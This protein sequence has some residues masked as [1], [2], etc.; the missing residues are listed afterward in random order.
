MSYGRIT[1]GLRSVEMTKQLVSTPKMVPVVEALTIPFVA[2]LMEDGRF[3]PTEQHE[4]SAASMLTELAKWKGF[5]NAQA[6][7]SQL[8]SGTSLAR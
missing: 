6:M 5:G 3:K 2:T 7:T 8:C 4:R 1:G